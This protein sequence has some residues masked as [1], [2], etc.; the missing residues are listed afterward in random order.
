[1][2]KR[3][4]S[5]TGKI[6]GLI[7]MTVLIVGGATFGSSFYFLSKGYDEQAE[8]EVAMTSK[9]IQDNFDDL[10]EKV[11]TPPLL[12]PAGRTS[13]RPWR[14]RTRPICRTSARPHGHNE[15]GFVTIADKEGNVIA[16]GH[17]DKT[18][19]S[20]TN[21]INVKKALAGEVS[22]GYRVG[23]RGE[24]LPPG[25]GARQDRWPHRRDVTSGIDLPKENPF[26]D[27][28]KKRFGVECTIFDQDERVTTTLQRD[29]KRII[30]T[31]MDNPKVIET[32]LRNGQTFLNRNK[33]QGEDYNTAYWPIMGADGKISRDVL[34]RKRPDRHRQVAT[35][36]SSGRS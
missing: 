17:S 4:V 23:N 3:N 11:K 14:R 24:A 22:V 8:K 5:L 2:K 27:D 1:M 13:P 29:G 10:K 18:G 26:V 25:G 31:K 33:I 19:D 32:V 20:V 9:M 30:G 21:Q 7:I 36:A 28:I 34:H 15:I 35:G 16:S 12:L 6:I